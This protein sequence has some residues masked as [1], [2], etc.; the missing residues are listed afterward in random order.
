M[1]E[2]SMATPVIDNTKEPN[3]TQSIPVKTRLK[4]YRQKLMTLKARIRYREHAIE[5]FKKHLKDGRMVPFR[6]E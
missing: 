4:D 3:P 6:K 1:S 5:G 2:S